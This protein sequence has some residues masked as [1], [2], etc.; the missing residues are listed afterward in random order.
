MKKTD[1]LI[2]ILNGK[3]DVLL[4][5][6]GI[7]E[8]DTKIVKTDEKN[9]ARFGFMRR[10]VKEYKY[11]QIY[12][13]CIE[14]GLQR[15]RFFINLYILLSSARIG[16]IIDEKGEILKYSFLRFF[17]CEIPFFIFEAIISSIVVVY[18]HIKLPYLKWKLK[19]KN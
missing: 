12:F 6:N 7:N 13:A 8:L 4:H 5:E 16:G 2:I 3:A 14:A 11:K 10:L 17:F 19:T 1:T 9:L 18:F 15:F